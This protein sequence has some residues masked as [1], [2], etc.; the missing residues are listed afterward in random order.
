VQ[1]KGRRE[2]VTV[3][4]I[5]GLAGEAEPP[6]W[7]THREALRLCRAGEADAARRLLA[8]QDLA[9]DPAAAALAAALAADPGFRGLF[10][11]AP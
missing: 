1:V 5:A 3:F 7:A 10:S 8:G 4:E 6:G 9:G 11:A 2:A